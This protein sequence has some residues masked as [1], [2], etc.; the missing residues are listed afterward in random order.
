MNTPK[1]FPSVKRSYETFVYKKVSQKTDVVMAIPQG[2]RCFAWFTKNEKEQPVC[3]LMILSRYKKGQPQTFESIRKMDTC[4]DDELSH[5]TVLYG[6]TFYYQK[7]IFFA[8]EDVVLYK[9]KDLRAFNNAE[10]LNTLFAIFNKDVKQTAYHE[11]FLVFGMPI[12][13]KT[14]EEF[15]ITPY[16]V[17]HYQHIIFSNN[18]KV[19]Y[20]NNPSLETSPVVLAEELITPTVTQNPSKTL[21]KNY[22]HKQNIFKKTQQEK[23]I[24]FTVMPDIQNDIYYLKNDDGTFNEIAYIPDYKTSVMM[25]RMFRNIKENQNLDALEES[26]SE[27]EFENDK[28]DKFVYLQKSERMICTYHHKFK[29]WVPIRLE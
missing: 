18:N 7:K 26:D 21:S 15:T 29:K 13:K 3:Y 24:V 11:N 19:N 16:K 2:K 6:T 27:D 20:I 22:E 12:M 9:G 1:N 8:V 14:M 5:G 25:N 4:F 10:K 23:T 17:S 28:S